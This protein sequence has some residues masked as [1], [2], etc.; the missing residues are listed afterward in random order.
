MPSLWQEE[1]FINGGKIKKKT[2]EQKNLA[3]GQV[4]DK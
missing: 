4:Q 1:M 3:L 2:A